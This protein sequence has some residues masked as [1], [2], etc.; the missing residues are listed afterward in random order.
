MLNG[1]TLVLKDRDLVGDLRAALGLPQVP[2][3][4]ENDA[5]CFALGEALCGA[6]LAHARA[7]GTATREHT[8]VGIIL[9]T[10]CGGGVVLRGDTLRGRRGGAGELGHVVLHENGLRCWCG[11]VGCAEQYLSGSGLE[12]QFNMRRYSQV[13]EFQDARAI[14]ELARAGDPIAVACVK[15]FRADLA[16]F[17]SQMTAVFD[18][19]FFVLGGGVSLQD[20]VYVDLSAAIARQAFLPDS[21]VPVYRNRLGDSAGVVGASLLIVKDL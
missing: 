11:Q 8:S 5:N 20:D 3:R 14:F 17:L 7:H 12:Q 10:G 6:G 18:P 15:A 4:A 2:V 16:R 9:G 21:F 13:R 19:D 1:N